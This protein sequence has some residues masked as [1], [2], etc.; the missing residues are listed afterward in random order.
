MP[1]AQV[2]EPE[3]CHERVI[4]TQNH[5]DVTFRRVGKGWM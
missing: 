4:V 2:C 1:V 3:T 5:R